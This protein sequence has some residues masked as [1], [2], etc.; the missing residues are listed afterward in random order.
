MPRSRVLAAAWF[1]LAMMT[2]VRSQQ[3]PP[4]PVLP[5]GPPGAGV[6]A[7]GGRTGR[8][9]AAVDPA[10]I[11]RGR[12]LFAQACSFCH[13]GDA[14][15][16]AEGGTDLTRSPIITGDGTATQLGEFL[17]V[18]R[19]EKKMPPFPMP[20]AQTADLAAFLRSL[21]AAGRGG[22]RGITA[23]VVGDATAGERFFNGA[24]HCATCHSVTG[25]LKAVGAKYPVATLQGRIVLPR[26][27][28]GYP[29]QGGARDGRSVKVTLPD[30]QIYAGTL[31]SISDF[32]LTMVDAAGLRRSI[33]RNGSQPR[34][35]VTDPLQAHLDMMTKLTDK[36]MHDVTA[37]LVTLK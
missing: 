5:G 35:E 10:A 1:A 15:G 3:P 32:S 4:Q 28:G 21:A 30:G 36:D 24:G 37:Y 17:K 7:G 12:L 25:D 29:G 14:R 6:Q 9:Q 27:T 16:G 26:G 11:E 33:E 31:V 2:S 23:A 18:G 20:D 8:D 34:V 13:G 22:G 19:P